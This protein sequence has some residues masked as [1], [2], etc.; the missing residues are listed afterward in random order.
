MQNFFPL[1]LELMLIS[2]S[3]YSDD[4]FQEF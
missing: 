4:S 2:V 3:W 1:A